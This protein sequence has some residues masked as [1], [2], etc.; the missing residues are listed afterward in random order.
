M[1]VNSEIIENGCKSV[2]L[3]KVFLLSS[4]LIL[5]ISG[6]DPNNRIM[7]P[8][9]VGR[10]RPTPAVNVILD[11]LGVEDEDVSA[12]ADAED[13][14]DIDAVVYEDDYTFS[15]GDVVRI[16]IHELLFENTPYTNDFVV[17]ESGN[18]NVIEVGLVDV[19]GLTEVQLV[20][21]L[22]NILSPNKL[23]D[24]L[25]TVTLLRSER[26]MFSIAG[27][28]VRGA[29]R[30]AIP[31]YD[32]RLLDAIALAGGMGQHNYSYVYVARNPAIDRALRNNFD[33]MFPATTEIDTEYEEGDDVLKLL[34]SAGHDQSMLM[35][36]SEM[37]TDAEMLGD[38][39]SGVDILSS[40]AELEVEDQ[41]VG[42][43]EWEFLRDEGKWVPVKSKSKPPSVSIL[44]DVLSP[45]SEQPIQE[46]SLEEPIETGGEV[47]FIKIPRDKL[48]TGDPHYNIVIREK[49]NIYIP[50]DIMGEFM[51]MGNIN[52][53]GAY[54]LTGRPITLKTAISLAG[55]F[56]EL[57]Q[58]KR[59]EITRRIGVDREET[60]MVDLDKIYR[61]EQPDFF[62]KPL[63]LINVGTD[64][65]AEWRYKLRNA[66]SAQYGFGFS[67]SR[68]FGNREL[69]FSRPL[70]LFGIE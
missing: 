67:Y 69:S 63:D 35:L 58:P 36:S 46:L 65:F 31:R 45:Q 38:N 48:F 27:V 41:S 28:G 53:P 60:V 15:S 33:S 25:V 21:E 55:G 64:Q 66:F 62:V 23:K 49:D 26:R 42:D 29:G 61:G 1:R 5:L 6:C 43:V 12:F 13:P 10:F 18:I 30:Y 11:E 9:Q 24:P 16:S 2:C 17:N 59:C 37:G 4:L 50:A 3:R 70:G 47:R 52:G 51:I 14:L 44:S 19:L 32:F 54:P 56:G 34:G 57:A 22:K 8:K 40:L 39:R 7:D 68:G 20:E